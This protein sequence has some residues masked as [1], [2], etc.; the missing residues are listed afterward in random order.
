MDT[1]PIGRL[2]I[3]RAG[4][5]KG[6]PFLIVGIWDENHVLLADGALRTMLRPKKKKLRHLKVTGVSSEAIRVQLE[7][8]AKPL[9]ADIRKELCS[10]GLPGQEPEQEG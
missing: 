7:K 3:S 5:D 8:G 1:N 9:D 6:R 2:V 4:R 10:L